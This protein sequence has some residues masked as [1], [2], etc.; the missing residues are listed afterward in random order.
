MSEAVIA[1]WSRVNRDHPSDRR[2]IFSID[3]KEPEGAYFS[4]DLEHDSGELV[5]GGLDMRVS[6]ELRERGYAKQLLGAM[7]YIALR[8][9]AARLEVAVESPYVLRALRRVFSDDGLSFYDATPYEPDG[10]R[11][12]L[13]INDAIES[14]E[15]ATAYEDNLDHRRHGVVVHADFKHVK[16]ESLIEP[17]ETKV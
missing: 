17:R 8:E 15:R 4:A 2:I 13:S 12:P 9:H 10:V 7:A 11:L 3:E 5:I 16:S 14:L 6:P 1:K